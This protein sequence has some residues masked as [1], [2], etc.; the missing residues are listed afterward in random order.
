MI[1]QNDKTLPK[2]SRFGWR[3]VLGIAFIAVIVTALISAWWV[4]QNIYA[5]QFEPTRLSAKE[6]QVLDSK[7]ARLEES[8]VKEKPS[9]KKAKPDQP[10]M[11]LEPESYSEDNAKRE[12]SLSEKELNALI[13][14]DPETAK[15]VAI[16]LAD[17]LVSVKLLVPVDEDFPIL[18]GK[19]LRLFFGVTLSYGKNRPIVAIRGVSLGGVPLPSAWWGD[20]KNKNLVEEFGSEGGFWDLFSKGVED[21]KIREG[22]LRIKLKE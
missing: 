8:A 14:K 5:S 12:I 18:G 4:K 22:H 13:A 19:T 2:T 11:S 20:I 21:I 6:Q 10:R 16:D 7:L 9:L 1:E 15:R 17:D 3:H